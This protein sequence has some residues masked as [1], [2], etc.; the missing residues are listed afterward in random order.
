VPS[1][2]AA[3]ALTLERPDGTSEVV[4]PVLAGIPGEKAGAKLPTLIYEGTDPAGIYTLLAQVAEETTA[5]AAG[6]EA[7][8]EPVVETRF[9][10]N[11]DTRES[12]LTPLDPRDIQALFTATK[13]EYVKAGED[14]LDRIQTS[15]HGREVWRSL[16]LLV[17]LLLMTESVLSHQIDRA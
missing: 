9:C 17:C 14:V 16:L 12:D 4:R 3:A 6:N 7:G 13:A 2:L 10:V 15:R 1:R 5:E 11:V 8:S